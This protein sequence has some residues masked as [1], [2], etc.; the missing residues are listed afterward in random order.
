M[1]QR[2]I[3]QWGLEKKHKAPEMRAILRLARQRKAAGQESVFRIRGRKTD[4]E[5]VYRYFKRRGEDPNKLDVG[6]GPIPS[7]IKVETPTSQHPRTEVSED[8]EPFEFTF[9]IPY[10][11]PE[12]ESVYLVR[13]GA[14]G[15]SPG[16]STRSDSVVST[17]HLFSE[18]TFAGQLI[19]NYTP[20][21]MPIGTTVDVKCSRILLHLTQQFFDDVVPKIFFTQDGTKSIISTPW[22]RSLSTWS[23]A[24]SE[25]HELMQRGQVD[26]TLLDLRDKAHASVKK[27]IQNPSP[28][29]LLRYFEIIHALRN[30]GDLRDE[31]Y[32]QSTLT[33]VLKMAE[34]VLH[35]YHPIR[36]LTLLLRTPEAKPI[37]G[38]LAQL[39]IQRSIEI[40]FQ[41]CGPHHPRILYV[42]DS[43]TQTLLDEH[44]YEE[45]SRQADDYLR[46]A[47]FVG[48]DVT[49]ES[50][51]ALRM[52]G[53][54]Y[55]GQGQLDKAV[56]AYTKAFYLQ[57]HITSASDK[58]RGVIGVRTQRG[59]AGI[60]SSRGRFQ[61]AENNLQ[62]ALQI[63]R[64]AF[65]EEDVQVKLVQD[66]LFDVHERMAQVRGGL[67]YRPLDPPVISG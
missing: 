42:L 33:Y 20:M 10:P 8:D 62:V 29:I 16:S 53:D 44:K 9:R 22:R 34:T 63:A 6:D 41:R 58:D 23:R 7:T 64:S 66:D 2:K 5:E 27:H 59:L 65:G 60:A 35:P 3:A 37:I 12:M 30:S 25:G 50:C 18:A 47:E 49:Y 52:S 61:D 38:P 21:A 36:Q 55:V 11:T 14:V 48:A 67:A 24:T 1:Y 4:I 13:P 57:R 19:P 39:G 26:G 46:R 40:L 17:P 51:Q 43:R 45:A 28:I 54:A 15:S 31:L 32:L 56:D